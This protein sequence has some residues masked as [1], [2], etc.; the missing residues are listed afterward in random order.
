[1]TGLPVDSIENAEIAARELIRRGAKNVIVTLGDKGALFVN[2][3][4]VAHFPAPTVKVVDTTAAGDSFTAAFALGL[5]EGK[6][7]LE[8]MS[9]A[10]KVSTIVVTKKGAQTSIPDKKE[11]DS[12]KM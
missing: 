11:V 4:E 10:I 2:P 6:N 9:F 5:S 3:N 12:W 1:L 7:H 8:A